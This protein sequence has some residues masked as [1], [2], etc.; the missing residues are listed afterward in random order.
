MNHE[1]AKTGYSAAVRIRHNYPAA[2][3]NLA[4]TLYM[5]DEFEAAL[6]HA[7][8]AKEMGFDVSEK[9]IAELRH[10]CRSK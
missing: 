2:H 5:L 4:I 9:L 8:I 1:Q 7:E 3:N 6:E 10:K